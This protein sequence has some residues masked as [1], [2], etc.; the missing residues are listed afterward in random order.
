MWKTMLGPTTRALLIN[1]NRE[2]TELSIC[3]NRSFMR[4]AE[5]TQRNADGCTEDVTR[6]EFQYNE[7]H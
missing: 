7:D 6:I 2:P 1:I 4:A 3:R 5:R